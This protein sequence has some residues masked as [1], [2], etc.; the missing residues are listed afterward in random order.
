[1]VQLSTLGGKRATPGNQRVKI[2]KTLKILSCLVLLLAAFASAAQSNSPLIQFGEQHV[3]HSKILN[4]DRPYW[5]CLPP[6]CQS[7]ADRGSQKYPV[8]YLLDGE[9]NFEWACEVVRF[10]SGSLE[11]PELIIVGIP[12]MNQDRERDL[13]PTHDT[14][15]VSSGGGELFERFLNE[16]LAPEINAKYQTVLYRI[17]AG[18]SMGGALAADVFLRQTNGFQACLAI[19]PSLW[20]DNEVLV[21]RARKFVPRRNSR[22]SIFIATANWPRSLDPTN[23][24]TGPSELFVSILK[25]NSSPGICVGYRHFESEDHG[26]SRLMGLYDGLR[27]IFD[28]YK[29]LDVLALD[30]PSLIKNHFEKLSDRL[31]FQILPPAGFVNKIGCGLLDAHE[32]DKAVECFKVNVSNYPASA[33]AYSYLAD[34]YL[35][36]G[37]KALAIQNYKAALKLNPNVDS[38]KEAL[39][40][41]RP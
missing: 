2:V 26:S 10:M 3:L 1:V 36:A 5:V 21:Q 34:A 29:P 7:N 13:T 35:A 11:I 38:A 14:N 20:W 22:S 39:K 40:K 24:M 31:G 9:W 41:L 28:G 15:D 8:L 12:N 6:S 16:E 18:H 25:T 30:E 32:S 33:Y 37:E 17:L 23:T 27:F 4:E 19:D